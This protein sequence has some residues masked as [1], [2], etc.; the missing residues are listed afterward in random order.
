MRDVPSIKVASLDDALS[1]ID[2]IVDTFK[3]VGVL[4]LQ[5][6]SFNRKEQFK[7]ACV[8]GDTFKW[9]FS[10]MQVGEPIP[11]EIVDYNVF[12]GGH[13]DNPNND[14]I[15]KSSYVLDWHIE[16]VFYIDPFLAGFWNMFHVGFE[17]PDAGNT[18]FVDSN[19]I[20]NSLSE[21]EKD[22]L[23]K[24]VFIWDKPVGPKTGYGPFYNKA[25][26]VSPVDGKPIIR[27]ETDG[28]CIISPSLYRFDGEEPSEEQSAQFNKLVSK[29]IKG[30]LQDDHS[31]RYVQKWQEGDLIIV[32][33]FRMY[34]AVT[35]GFGYG[36]R[37]F[38]GLFTR[39]EGYTHDHY[40]SLELA[41]TN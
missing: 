1:K 8:M 25:I 36:E 33:L 26:D 17:D 11:D 41:W 31:I 4:K 38:Y 28:G 24:C 14:T 23:S 37:E 18:L 15:D 16:Q 5:G 27:V 29:K 19:E 39:P 3:T 22:F 12:V 40:N 7:L 20:Y 10:C 30:K 21:D 32:D 9:N 34:H 2:S 13:S 35:G 6:H